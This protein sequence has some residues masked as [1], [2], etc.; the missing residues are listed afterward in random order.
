[1]SK[2][3]PSIFNDVIGPVMR[4]AS[5]SHCAAALR[6]GL[7]ARDL[8]GGH[9]ESVLVEYDTAG[10]LATTH[11]SHGSDMGLWGGLL[12]WDASHEDLPQSATALKAA[13]IIAEVRIGEFG[14]P[15][16]NTYRLTL[17]NTGETRTL[18]AVSTG[19]GMIEVIAIDDLPLSILGDR[20]ET[21]L[22]LDRTDAAPPAGLDNFIDA[23]QVSIHRSD[24]L[25][26]VQISSG[27][28]LDRET[29]K[30]TGPGSVH[31]TVRT[32][33]PVVPIQTPKTISLPFLSCGEMFDHNRQLSLPLWELAVRYE[34]ARG[35]I[36][37][38]EVFEKMREV[39]RIMR[40]AIDSGVAGTDYE[41]RILGWQSGNFRALQEQGRLLDGGMLNAMT[42]AVT[43]TMESK[44]A[45]GVVVAAPT[46]GSCGV[47]PGA[48]LAAAEFMGKSEDEAVKSLLAAGL[49]GVFIAEKATF[50]AEVG[51]CQAECGSASGMA[52]AGLVTLAGG[53]VA[54]AVSA[55]SMALQNC[56]G[57]V[58]DPIANRVEAPCLG[59][60]VLAAANA[61]AA[62]NMALADFDALIPL[63]EVIVAMDQVGRS[64]PHQL[65]CTALGGL[66]VTRTSLAI[67]ERL[68]RRHGHNCK[69]SCTGKESL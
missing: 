8:M 50:A 38:A 25:C 6:I 65:R 31:Q 9:I 58:C 17:R 29:L 15:H 13:G 34:S 59:K 12:G 1:M 21:L 28:P 35:A 5:S 3:P 63:D 62:A 4:G 30:L 43:A 19:G 24:H 56:F 45:M 41:D 64:L 23:D 49:I 22:F 11:N 39:A 2:L 68:K 20:F 54:Q 36:S 52:A 44:S 60:N 27:M 55:A 32:L 14:D 51:G 46:A 67:E 33:K 69:M 26:L 7:I 66:S 42:L 47:L 53:S 40:G 48:C 61:L 57:M 16:P 37:E 10:S 18:R